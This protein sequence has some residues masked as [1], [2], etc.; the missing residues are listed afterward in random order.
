MNPNELVLTSDG[1]HSL[2]S[3]RFGVDYHSVHGAIQESEHVFIGGGLLPLLETGVTEVNILEMGFGTGLNALLV[4]RLAEN[5]PEVSFNYIAYE[6]FP[7][8]PV[9]VAALNYPDQL[10]IEQDQF[11][12]LHDCGWE[13]LHQLAPNFSLYKHH[14]DYLTDADRPYVPGSINL[15]F[16]DAFAPASQPEFWEPEGLLVSY[17]ALGPNGTLITYCAK[18]QFKRNLKAVG[19]ALEPL[20]GPPGKRE[21]TRGRKSSVN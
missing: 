11:V 12:S 16:Y 19:F 9:E 14:A 1:S 15:V 17:N 20:P 8:S 3:R 13:M 5:Y 10:E 2:R 6:K 18:G 21:M 7:V 4:R